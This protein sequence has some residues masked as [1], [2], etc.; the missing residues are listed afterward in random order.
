MY[1]HFFEEDYYGKQ[2]VTI[3][4]NSGV[5]NERYSSDSSSPNVTVV[6]DTP[7]FEEP[8]LVA[9]RLVKV[10]MELHEQLLKRHGLFFIWTT[11]FT[12]SGRLLRSQS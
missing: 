4:S 7:A 6:F 9:A 10:L 2:K 12:N 1:L 8:V 5:G 3:P 11:P